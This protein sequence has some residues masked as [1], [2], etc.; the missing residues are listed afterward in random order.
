[1]GNLEDWKRELD[2]CARKKQN[3]IKLP[4]PDPDRTDT[5]NPRFLGDKKKNLPVPENHQYSVD[6]MK[7][8]FKYC[9]Q[10][11]IRAMLPIGKKYVDAYGTDHIY[12]QDPYPEHKWK[13]SADEVKKELLKFATEI[14]SSINS[15]D[16]EGIWYISGWAFFADPKNW[17]YETVKQFMDVVP[18]DRF[19]VCDVF[20]ENPVF[21]KHNY[22]HGRKWGIGFL[23]TFGMM[24]LLKGDMEGMHKA[25]MEL[26]SNPH[27]KNCKMFY[28][29]PESTHN[30]NLY[31]EFAT[32]ISWDPRTTNVDDFIKDFS[33][34]RYGKA[35]AGTMD[36]AWKALEK[37]VYSI[38]DDW[39][40]PL[41]Q[42]E[43][44][45]PK[46]QSPK[47]VSLLNDL[48]CVKHFSCMDFVHSTDYAMEKAISCE[49]EQSG[50]ILYQYDIVDIFRT[51]NYLYFNSHVLKLLSAYT[52]GDTNKFQ[53]HLKACRA[54][55]PALEKVLASRWDCWIKYQS[56]LPW[57]F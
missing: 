48:F 7:E 3:L 21:Q 32:K 29:N 50:N 43:L 49:K 31:F 54:S 20:G 51:H 26:T 1:M 46:Y 41:Y 56:G 55:L 23:N 52:Q 24:H 35:S 5:E 12:N 39:P 57:N 22:F 45:T 6:M 37:T 42:T 47:Q 44:G 9:R 10:L 13:M 2:W 53:Y 18:A 33:L 25:A 8:V 4:V 17:S 30:N 11:G 28:I 34:R 38:N 15:Y 27:A 36:K 19:Y 14:C 40:T 16:P